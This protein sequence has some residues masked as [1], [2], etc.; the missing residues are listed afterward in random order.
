MTGRDRVAALCRAKPPV[1]MILL[2]DS[3]RR[4]IDISDDCGDPLN[5]EPGWPSSR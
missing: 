3:R 5:L 4:S 2:A 1:H